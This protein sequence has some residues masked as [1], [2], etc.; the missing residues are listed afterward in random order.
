MSGH[1][2]EV[3]GDGESVTILFTNHAERTSARVNLSRNSCR[4]LGKALLEASDST[5]PMRRAFRESSK[6]TEPTDA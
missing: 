5:E 1:S 3:K 4:D 2:I 6:T